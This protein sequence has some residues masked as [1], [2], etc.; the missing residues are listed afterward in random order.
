[1][2]A[3]D[4]VTEVEGLIIGLLPGGNAEVEMA[5]GHCIV[6]EI[7]A[8]IKVRFIGLRVGERVRCEISPYDPAKVRIVGRVEKVN[9]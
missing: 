3:G 7:S 4:R 6:A 8:K 5:D 1:M 9:P 2:D